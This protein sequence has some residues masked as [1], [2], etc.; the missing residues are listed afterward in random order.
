MN[1]SDISKSAIAGCQL[2]LTLCTRREAQG[3]RVLHRRQCSDG[4]HEGECRVIFAHCV[5][6]LAR[7][8]AHSGP[9]QR[10]RHFRGQGREAAGGMHEAR[11]ACGR[12]RGTRRASLWRSLM[13]NR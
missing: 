9:P 11:G 7:A 12:K 4:V 5:F 13:R 3:G 1:A 8:P 6:I 2:V 10:A